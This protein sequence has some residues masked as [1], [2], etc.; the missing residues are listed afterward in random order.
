VCVGSVSLGKEIPQHKL[1]T[2]I[3]AIAVPFTIIKPGEMKIVGML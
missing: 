1:G 3:S 2:G